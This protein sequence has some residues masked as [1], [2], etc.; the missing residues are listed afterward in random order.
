MNGYIAYYK[1]QRL[2]VYAETLYAAQTKAAQLLK[3]PSKR[4]YQ[5]HTVL[6]ELNGT[7]VEHVAVD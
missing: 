7:P 6:A 3:V 2:E 5:V 4:Q 1:G